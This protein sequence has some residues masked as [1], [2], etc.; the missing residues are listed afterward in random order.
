MSCNHDT[1]TVIITKYRVPLR[2]LF[3][4]HGNS[5]GRESKISRSGNQFNLVASNERITDVRFLKPPRRDLKA[6]GDT[7]HKIK[8]K[9]RWA[10]EWATPVAWIL[11][12]IPSDRKIEQSNTEVNFIAFRGIGFPS[13]MYFLISVPFI[14][15][16]NIPLEFCRFFSVSSVISQ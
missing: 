11:L 14:S 8:T 10:S 7:L 15:L 13:A 3:S 2:S 5:E 4:S 1:A 12:R 6:P 9:F 16:M